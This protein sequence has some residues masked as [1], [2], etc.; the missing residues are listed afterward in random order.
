MRATLDVEHDMPARVT[1]LLL[2]QVMHDIFPWAGTSG[3][4]SLAGEGLSE[5]Q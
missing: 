2:Q 5:V 1:L 3:N 4:N